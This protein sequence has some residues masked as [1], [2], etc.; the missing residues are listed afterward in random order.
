MADILAGI[1]GAFVLSINDRP[2][3]REWFGAFHLQ[4]VQLKYTV[5]DGAGTAAQ[6]IIISNRKVA[7]RLL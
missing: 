3:V 1:K 5:S 6:E 4:S 2:E 7:G